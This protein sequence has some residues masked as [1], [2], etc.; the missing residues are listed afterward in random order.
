MTSRQ[1]DEMDAAATVILVIANL[2]GK[3]QSVDLLLSLYAA[4]NP[5]NSS[6]ARV[7]E[8]SAQAPTPWRW[9]RTDSIG[10]C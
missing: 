6:A 2:S 4:R 9:L 10:S 7:F 5:S 8:S 3:A 1:A